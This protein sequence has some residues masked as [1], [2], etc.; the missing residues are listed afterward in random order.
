MNPTPETKIPSARETFRL[1][2]RLLVYTRPYRGVMGAILVLT[3]LGS[4]GM[5]V[6]PVLI[7]NAVDQ[8]IGDAT[9]ALDVRV[10]GLL[11]TGALFFGISLA[12]LVLRYLH[13][14][15]AARMG[16]GVVRDIRHDVFRKALDLHLQ[17]FD[18]TPVGRLMTRVTSDVDTLQRFVSDGVVG[19]VADVFQILG[20]FVFMIYVSPVLSLAL[21]LIIPFMAAAFLFSNTRVR[22]ANREIRRAQSAL[23]TNAQE[24]L[25]GMATIQLFGRE[26]TIRER[27]ARLNGIMRDAC[28]LEVRWFSFYFPVLDFA[29]AVAT[30]LVLGV[31]GACILSGYGAV[32]LG[33]LIAFLTYVR[34]FFR[35]L[36]GLSNRAGML[37]Q[38]LAAS[39]RIFELLEEPQRIP[40]PPAPV[41]LPAAGPIA[42]EHVHFAYVEENWVLRDVSFRI[43][44]GETVAIV[45][46]TGSG[47]TT[48]INLLL[49]FYDVQQ[50]GIS[51]GGIDLRSV[52]RHDLRRRIG[53]VM[54]E[55]FIFSASVA[56]NVG[57]LDPAISRATIEDAARYANA[58]GFIRKLPHGYD[59]VLNE[60]GGGLS[61]G[62]KQLLALARAMA[63]NRNALLILDEATANVDSETEALIQDAI[64]RVMKNRTGIIIAHRLSTI[65]HAHR[66]LVLYQGK[67]VAQGTHDEL[68][69]Q[70][71]YYRR[72]YRYLSLNNGQAPAPE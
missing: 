20:V 12:S 47:K 63:Q 10:N 72:L 23:N 49:R 34:D 28:F 64:R 66:I 30:I 46:A 29:Q 21:F 33:V 50:G 22:I 4:V 16:A 5:N 45:G 60:R 48:L 19:A 14:I 44:P 69:R 8:W 13:A 3:I 38:A 35:P 37:Q 41:P 2:R 65:R 71:G 55:P 53:A 70:D 9:L 40:D 68:L 58:D 52:R 31:G 24:A 32:T 25:A 57:L 1:L 39:E 59:T 54:Q 42:F 62:Q 56:D 61:A 51:I 27:F 18:R 17:Y 7:R 26:P 36:D 6:P 43:E 11:R 67:L 15:V